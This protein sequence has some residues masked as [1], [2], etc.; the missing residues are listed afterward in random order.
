MKINELT[1]KAKRDFNNA[2]CLIGIIPFLVFLYLLAV[3]MGS[4]QILSGEIGYLFLIAIVL[5]LLGI[6]AGRKILLGLTTQLIEKNRL[7]TITETVLTLGHEI[8]NPLMVV[9]GNLELLASDF[10]KGHLP[11]PVNERL[12]QIKN[13]CQRIREAVDKMGSLSKPVFTSIQGSA[14]KMIDLNKSR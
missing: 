11:T 2:I 12:N 13:H 14:A 3:K 6:F 9:M 4:L 7:A 8:N 1:L 5:S 10:I